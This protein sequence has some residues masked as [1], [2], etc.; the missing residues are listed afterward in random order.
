MELPVE[1]YH[2]IFSFLDDSSLHRCCFFVCKKWFKLLNLEEFWHSRF[3]QRFFMTPERGAKILNLRAAYWNKISVCNNFKR[4][5]YRT[6]NLSG[7]VD[8]ITCVQIAENNIFTGSLDRTL[9][10][11]SF[12]GECVSTLEGHTSSIIC[13]KVLGT[14]LLSFSWNRILKLWDWKKGV[15]LIT[16]ESPF[17]LECMDFNDEVVVCGSSD[18]QI[19][20]FE[21]SNVQPFILKK[22][23]GPYLYSGILDVLLFSNNIF[24]YR[25][26]LGNVSFWNYKTKECLYSHNFQTPWL[27][28]FYVK[29]NNCVLFYTLKGAEKILFFYQNGK[30]YVKT[31]SRFN[32]NG[33]LSPLNDIIESV[34]TAENFST[35]Y[36]F[37]S[38]NNFG[39]FNFQENSFMNN[40]PFAMGSGSIAFS[41]GD[42]RNIVMLND[43]N[44]V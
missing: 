44:N 28:P 38:L 31:F 43:F 42:N 40:I 13:M 14:K 10:V 25:D 29:G 41:A 19:I 39:Y 37:K 18:G 15:C 34:I 30:F 9:R 20:I 27:V 26:L 32:E 22:N 35:S 12:K 21:I 23:N 5:K 36:T 17:Y 33:K 4:N 2:Y 8:N 7:H 11:W 1:I 24:Y 6:I 3:I 16:F